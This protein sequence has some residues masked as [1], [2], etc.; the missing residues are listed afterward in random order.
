MRLLAFSSSNAVDV[1]L[2]IFLIVVGFALAY[3]FFRL[4]DVLGR[5]SGTI[6]RTENEVLPVIR[7]AGGTLDRVNVQLD[8]ADQVTTS[9][10]DAVAAIDKAV[11]AI[12]AAVT[13]P[14]QKLSGFVAGITFGASSLRTHR[15]FSEAVRAGK[16]AASRREQDL[17]DELRREE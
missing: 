3:A 15:D 14:I 2:T 6:R 16:E 4:A 8:K 5:V 17:A 10:V 12:S 13:V 7:K 11:R 9:A 1:A